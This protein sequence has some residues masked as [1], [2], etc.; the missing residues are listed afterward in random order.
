MVLCER[1]AHVQGGRCWSTAGGAIEPEESALDAA[2]REAG[3]ELTG[4]DRVVTGEPYI[5]ECADQ[6]GWSYTTYPAQVRSGSGRLPMVKITRDSFHAWETT[7]VKWFGVDELPA[8]LH[9]GLACRAWRRAIGGYQRGAVRS[10]GGGT[11]LAAA[12]SASRLR[13]R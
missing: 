12:A 10:R 13:C 1:S 8:D 4:L 11:G 6:C 2:L 7:S 3:E 9:P 5:A